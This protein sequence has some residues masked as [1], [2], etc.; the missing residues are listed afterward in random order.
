M[1]FAV[2]MIRALFATLSTA[3][4]STGVRKVICPHLGR[5]WRIFLVVVG[6]TARFSRSVSQGWLQRWPL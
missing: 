3:S 4:V 2:L 6:T 1:D 5:L